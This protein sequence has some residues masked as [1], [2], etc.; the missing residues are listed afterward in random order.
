LRRTRFSLAAALAAA[1]TVGL[2]A[3]PAVASAAPGNG[4][5]GLPVQLVAMNDF[6]GRIS[7]QT[8]S[9][10]ELVTSPGPDGDYATTADNVTE[11]VGGAAN[12]ATTL[13]DIREAWGG[14]Q[15]NTFLLL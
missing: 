8:G 11:K 7:P 15:K 4:A 3:V 12:V 5:G 2:L 9:D 14:P 1:T 6:H 10:G 13:S